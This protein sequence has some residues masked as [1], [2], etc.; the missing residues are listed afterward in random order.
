[1]D[2]EDDLKKKLKASLD[3]AQFSY[4]IAKL[5][6]SAGTSQKYKDFNH[7]VDRNVWVNETQLQNACFKSQE[8]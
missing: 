6:Q 3:T 2:S 5:R 1:M 8:S 7:T 4:R